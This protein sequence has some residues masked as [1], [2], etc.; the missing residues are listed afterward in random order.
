VRGLFVTGT[1]TNIGKTA[2]S[3]ALMHR[4]RSKAKLRY[5]KPVQTG[6]PPDNDTETVRILGGCSEDEIWDAGIRLPNPVSPHL[7]ARM[8]GVEIRLDAILASLPARTEED[9]WI[10]EGAGG[11]LVPINEKLL[12]TDLMS[13][14]ELSVLVVARAGLGTINHTLLTLEALRSRSLRVA[15]V[16]LVGEGNPDNALSIARYGGVEVLG[17]LPHLSELNAT[18]LSAWTHNHLD[19]HGKLENLMI[20]G[21]Q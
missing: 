19:P 9:A 17:Q 4:Y 13:A 8:A 5:W 2:I 14:L 7:A 3:A 1:D 18:S 15:A 11:V 10:V 16:V 6:F 12:M 20:G 21:P